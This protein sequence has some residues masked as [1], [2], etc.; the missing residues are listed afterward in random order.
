MEG[1]LRRVATRMG[2]MEELIAVLICGCG[3]P[4]HLRTSWSN[5]N[6]GRR[7]FGCKN[8]D[9]LVTRTE[10]DPADG[11]TQFPS[12]SRAQ[13]VKA[14]SHWAPQNLGSNPVQPPGQLCT[15]QSFGFWYTLP[16]V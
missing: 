14:L 16:L 10:P 1:G 7:F 4:A 11:L 5:D 13:P 9:S 15:A 6:P 12:R 2:E 8:H 3:V